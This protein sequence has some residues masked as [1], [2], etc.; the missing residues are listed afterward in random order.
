MDHDGRVITISSTRVYGDR[1]F[2]LK[3]PVNN[4]NDAFKNLEKYVE[5]L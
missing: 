1:A 3:L 4:L 5:Y 2:A